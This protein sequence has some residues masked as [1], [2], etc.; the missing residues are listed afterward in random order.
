M[1]GAG[2]GPEPLEESGLIDVKGQAASYVI[3]DGHEP[4]RARSCRA[5]R[6]PGS[7]A[8]SGRLV[9]LDRI[10][11]SFATVQWKPLQL[12]VAEVTVIG[13]GLLLVTPARTVPLPSSKRFCPAEATSLTGCRRGLRVIT[14]SCVAAGADQSEEQHEADRTARPAYSPHLDPR[15]P[16]AERRRT[17]QPFLECG[18]PASES[19]NAGHGLPDWVGDAGIRPAED[20]SAANWLMP[21]QSAWWDLVRYGPPGLDTYVR[22]A[23]QDSLDAVQ[24]TL[25]TLG[26]HTTTPDRG[27]RT[28]CALPG[29]VRSVAY[30]AP[31]PC[32]SIPPE[33][34]YS[35]NRVESPREGRSATHS[36]PSRNA[37]DNVAHE[38]MKTLSNYRARP[39]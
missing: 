12:M 5:V 3:D 26:E 25:A 10:V 6:L 16:S 7:A 13:L 2:A 1:L 23:F 8:E 18:A 27:S 4:R 31:T 20:A 35:E 15:I 34:R 17:G 11:A 39:A 28:G 38:W 32:T 9:G 19:R 22:V 37:V 29:V 24:V 33:D 21:S 30:G 14:R 36:L